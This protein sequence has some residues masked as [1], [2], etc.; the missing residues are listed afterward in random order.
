MAVMANLGQV[1]FQVSSKTVRTLDE[2][3][4]STSPRWA[5]HDIHLKKPKM[6]FIGPGKDSISF[7]V[8]LDKRLGVDPRKEAERFVILAQRGQ[9]MGFAVGGKKM[10]SYL[11]VLTGV[12]QREQRINRKGEITR[13]V[14]SL[15]LEEYAK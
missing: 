1:V 11:W 14:V 15:S 6:Q 9:P 7:T 3:T 2:L 13:L 10:G 12:E 8:T 5:T 4:R